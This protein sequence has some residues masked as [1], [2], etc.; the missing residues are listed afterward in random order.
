MVFFRFLDHAV[1]T[2]FLLLKVLI[3]RLQISMYKVLFKNFDQKIIQFFIV[4][5]R[6]KIAIK[7]QQVPTYIVFS[8][9]KMK[10]KI[11]FNLYRHVGLKNFYHKR[12]PLNIYCV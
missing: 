12:I 3:K 10:H 8:K 6:R 5:F 2:V 4:F 1:E 9:K 7:R 11:W